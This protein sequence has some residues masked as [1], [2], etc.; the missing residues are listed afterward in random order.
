MVAVEAVDCGPDAR[1]DGLSLG[2]P[3][4]DGD[5]GLVATMLGRCK[6]ARAGL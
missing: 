4:D 6:S 3:I 2:L 1:V 5:R